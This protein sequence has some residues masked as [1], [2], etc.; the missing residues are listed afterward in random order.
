MPK[1]VKYRQSEDGHKEIWCRS[2]SGFAYSFETYT[3]LV[4]SFHG[5]AAPGL[6]TG[7]KMVDIALNNLPQDILFDAICETS[8]CLPDAIQLL[9][10]CT[11][12]NGWLK[13][14]RLGRLAQFS[15]AKEVFLSGREVKVL[16]LRSGR[17][18][19]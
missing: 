14:L 12:G 19:S 7:G 5:H 4:K 18:G 10:P 15:R 13:I 11:I 17:T 2:S 3:E 6:I 9:T 16:V 1:E 8:N